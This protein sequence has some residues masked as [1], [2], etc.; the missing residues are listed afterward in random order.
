MDSFFII[1]NVIHIKYIS[2]L[3]DFNTRKQYKFKGKSTTNIEKYKTQK[4][5]IIF[6]FI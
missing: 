6:V 1:P 3:S 4:I 2:F 5:M